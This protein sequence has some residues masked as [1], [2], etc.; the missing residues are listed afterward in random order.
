MKII[1]NSFS[2]NIYI[3][4]IIALGV[5]CSL[6]IILFLKLSMYNDNND[7]AFTKDGV[8]YAIVVDGTR[9]KTIPAKD[10]YEV[11]VNCT[12]AEA[13]WLYDE[14]TLYIGEIS[15][16]VTC[17]LT[18]TTV[19]K[20]N[21]N[22]YIIKLSGKTQGMGQV[23][24]ENGYRYEGKNPNNYLWFNNELWRIIG[25]FDSST[26][27][28]AKTNLVKIIRAEVL[29]GLVWDT[30]NK[31]NWSTSSLNKLLNGAYYNAQNGTNTDYCYGCT[32]SSGKTKANCNYT[33]RGIQSAYK[34][35]IKNVTW[36]LGGYSLES[37]TESSYIAER[38]TSVYD[39]N[40]TLS[41]GYIGLMYPSD[42][43]YSVL[44]SNCARST[45]LGDYDSSK[46]AGQSWL[47]GKGYTWSITHMTDADFGVFVLRT[48]GDIPL[49]ASNPNS[50]DGYGIRPVLYLDA[51]VYKIAGDG[52]TSSP[53]IVGM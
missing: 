19:E 11:S 53:Y 23:V 4:I 38:G 12:N 15:G 40:E 48:Y 26:H 43:G 3:T 7:N 39:K 51:S 35:M 36:H 29:D 42:Y 2:K 5:I 45:M 22:N 6:I 24:K 44:A 21:L 50:C 46:C 14:W 31:N 8:K 1:K 52:S 37:T 9:S 18:F 10:L 16:N 41:K 33:Q 28:I 27:G 30:N 34:K 17:D 47:H 13:K 49:H 32:C 25:V 20:I